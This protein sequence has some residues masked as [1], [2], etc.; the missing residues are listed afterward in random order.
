MDR[1]HFIITVYCLVCDYYQMVKKQF[2]IRR[3]GFAPA[4]TDEEV[5]TIE[6]CGE[7]FKLN[8][9]QDIFD[10]FQAHYQADFP[11]L[12]DRSLF[13]RQAANLW[14]VKAAIHRLLVI[15]SGQADDP[16]QAIDTLPVPVC[17]YTRAPRDRCFKS[18]ADYGY[19][20]AKQMPYY[21]FKLGLRIARSGMITCYPLLPARPHDIQ[22]LETLVEN[23]SG[24]VPAD[25]GFIDAA[26]QALLH[27]R[28]GVTVITPA[29]KNM[30][31]PLPGQLRQLC[32]R[33]R[34]RI[35]TVGSQ[36]TERFAIG[37]IRV[38]DI[39]HFQHR[40]VRKILAHTIG[41]FL[42]LQLAR[43]PLD[44]DGLLA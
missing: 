33:W 2:K 19:C 20:A 32:Q 13:V 16:V 1:Y 9:D 30:S 27:E 44:L 21:G 29:R 38:R 31:E 25:K 3:G 23:F 36:L 37:R 4:L 35:E 18:E 42:N 11:Q 41:V 8:T 34:K 43:K 24:T 39:W 10:Y 14:Q 6:I 5:M 28:Q 7:Y 22:F 15:H 12:R 40:I 17:V 26:R